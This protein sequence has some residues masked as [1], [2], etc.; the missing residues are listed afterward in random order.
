MSNTGMER[1]VDNLGRIVIPIEIRKSMK[2]ETGNKLKI[3]VHGS[4]IIL[5]I[6]NKCICCGKKTNLK[7]YKNIF[8]CEKCL[9][10]INSSN[11]IYRR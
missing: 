2:I 5:S 6:T 7:K 8:I 11:L 4:D 10:K 9:K 3:A 1:K